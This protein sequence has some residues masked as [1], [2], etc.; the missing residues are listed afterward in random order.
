[1]IQDVMTKKTKQPDIVPDSEE[2]R[3]MAVS[4]D[5]KEKKR[6]ERKESKSAVR[7]LITAGR[8]T[9]DANDASK[10]KIFD[11]DEFVS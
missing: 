2:E 4:D 1:M 3:D 6:K 8:V 5:E 9:S 10:R 11:V 7:Q